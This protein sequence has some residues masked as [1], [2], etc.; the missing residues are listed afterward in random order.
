MQ[1]YVAVIIIISLL[2]GC[3]VEMATTTATVGAMEAESAQNAINRGNS[4]KDTVEKTSIQKAVDTYLAE[5]GA[6]PKSLKE[7]VPDYLPILPKKADGTSFGYNSST[8]KV[9]DAPTTETNTIPQ[10]NLPNIPK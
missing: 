1:K 6:Y 2:A 4:T 9:L 8:G 10:I 5:K 3:G 7:L